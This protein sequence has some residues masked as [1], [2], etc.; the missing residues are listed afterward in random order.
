MAMEEQFLVHGFPN[1]PKIF[2]DDG[3]GDGTDVDMVDLKQ[4]SGEFRASFVS[5]FLG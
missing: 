3:E 2:F 1:E 5:V 4:R